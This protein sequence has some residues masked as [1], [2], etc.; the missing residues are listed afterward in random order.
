MDL[1]FVATLTK[2]EFEFSVE[3]EKGKMGLMRHRGESD[4]ALRERG[5]DHLRSRGVEIS[6]VSETTGRLPTF[7]ISGRDDSYNP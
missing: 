7:R 6:E 5:L 2:I 1:V 3:G 4:T